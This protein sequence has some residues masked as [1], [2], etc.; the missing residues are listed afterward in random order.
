[1][2]PYKQFLAELKRRHV[3]RVAGIYGIVSFGI[4]Q[5][6]DL[7]LPRLGL[8]DWTVTFMVALV[9]LA[10]P[11]ALL[12]AWAFEV[13]PEGVQR[14][15]AAA[16]GVIEGIVAQPASKQWP[17]GVLALIGVTALVAGTWWIARRTAPGSDGVAGDGS[18]AAADVRLALTDLADDRRA[19]IAVL[20]FADMSS[21]GDQ[22][23]FGDGMTEEILNTLAK[24]RELRVAGRTS[25]FAYKGE[26][27]DLRQIG[28]EL[29]VEYLVEGSVRKEGDQLRITAQLIDAQDGS[30][31]WSDQYDRPLANVFQIQ[32]EIAEAIAKQLRVPLGL[33]DASQLVT[34]T[35]DLEAYDL[36]LAARSHMREREEAMGEAVRLF[37]AAVA[38]D[39]TWA[40]AWAGLAEATELITWYDEAWDEVPEEQEAYDAVVTALWDDSERAAR[41]ALQ[42]D[43]GNASAHVALGSVFR[44]RRQWDASEA[45]YLR[46]IDSDPD[47]PEAHQQYGE[48]LLDVGRIAE[49]RRA[50]ARAVGLDRVAVRVLWNAFGLQLDNLFP[51]ALKELEAGVEDFPGF[52]FL[53]AE[54]TYAYLKQGRFA[55]AAALPDYN[56]PIFGPFGI[57]DSLAKE[58][59]DR[60]RAGDLTVLPEIWRFSPELWMTFGQ[61]DSALARVPA[62]SDWLLDNTI[63]VWDPIFDPIRDDPVFQDA[64]RKLNL[65]GRTPQRTPRMEGD[66]DDGGETARDA[67][68]GSTAP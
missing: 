7:M 60:L 28:D 33:D 6:A 14:T 47:N 46:A 31:L 4:L 57:P 15:E 9:I 25:A 50:T 52:F 39:S 5:V 16:P 1:M 29:G 66:S 35:A 44:N 19:S 53:E 26:S 18:E 12:L 24:I 54:L 11:V 38:R 30:H 8:P 37:E 65:E 2:K 23:Y 62:R 58:T 67:S 49:G 63:W 10:F 20:P 27:K 13:T 17:A 21:A 68:L 41:R 42:L 32:T 51:E 61:P 64:L 3:F 40:P 55:D 43:P 56:H 59:A 22:E 34:P 48:M 45:A 36:Y